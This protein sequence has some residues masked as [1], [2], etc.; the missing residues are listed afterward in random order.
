MSDVGPIPTIDSS[1][2]ARRVREPSE[3]APVI[4]D[5]REQSEWDEVRIPGAVHVPLSRIAEE[6]T[7]LP[8]GRP[9]ILQCASGK[10]SL[11][12]AEFLRRNG[13]AD[14][15]N[16]VDGIKG[17]QGAGLPVERG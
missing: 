15:S 5:V 4:V 2:A 12:A 13:Y 17:W 14:V 3:E 1:E 9:L 10:R 8:Q 11:V 7:K 16:L 6:Y